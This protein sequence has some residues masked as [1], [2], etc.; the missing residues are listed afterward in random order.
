L[1]WS[2]KKKESRFNCKNVIGDFGKNKFSRIV[3]ANET[4]KHDVIEEEFMH[5]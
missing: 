2:E 3:R 1:E 5:L 4:W